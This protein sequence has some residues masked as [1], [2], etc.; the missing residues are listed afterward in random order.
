MKIPLIYWA[1]KIALRKSAGQAERLSSLLAQATIDL[2]PHQLHAVLFAFNSPL[3]RGAVLADEVGLGKTIEAGIVASQL[4][5]EDK[6][7]ILIIVPASLRKQWQEELETH[8][9]LR[10]TIVDKRY[11]DQ[12]INAGAPVPLTTEGIFIVSLPFLYRR[13]KLVEKQP[14]DLVIIDEAH[15]LRRVYRGRDA[16]KMAFELRKAIQDKPKLLLTAT[17]LQNDLLEVYGLVSFIDNKLL[18]SSYFFKTRFIEPIKQ[19]GAEDNPILRKIRE[20]ILGPEDGSDFE[21]PQGVVVRTL[22]R[23]VKHY[24]KFPPRQS[25]TADFDPGEQEWKLYE[26]VSAY[27]QRPDIAAIGRTQRNLMILV[28]RKLLASSSFAIAPT[29]KNLADRLRNELDLRQRAKKSEE[30]KEEGPEEFLEEAEEIEELEEAESLAGERITEEFSDED[31]KREINELGEYYNL[32]ISIKENAKGVALANTLKEVFIEAQRKGWPEKAIVFTESRRTQEYLRKTLV[33]NGFKITIFNGSNNSKEAQIAYENWKKEFPESA[34]QL[35]RSIAVRQALVHEFKTKTQVLLATEAGAEGL[36]LQFANIVVNYDLPWNPQRIE[37]RIGRSHRYGQNY[38]VLV[39]NMLNT[40]NYADKRLLELLQEKLNLFDGIFGSSDEILGAIEAG[41]DFD[42]KILEIYQTCKTPEEIDVAFEKLQ[43]ELEEARKKEIVDIRSRLI[44]YLDEPILQIFKK[45]KEETESVL[46]EYDEAMIN[47]C[48]LYFGDKMRA[49]KDTGLFEIEFKGEKK[50]YLFREEKEE[51]RGK[52]SRMH[53][54][55]PIIRHILGE[56]IKIVTKPIPIV[57]ILYTESGKRMHSLERLG[58]KGGMLYLFKLIVE[59][60]ETDE[61]LAPLFFIQEGNTWQALGLQ[62]GKFLIELSMRETA[63]GAEKS[64]LSKENLI[65]EWNKWKKQAVKRF[66]ERNERLYVREQARIER[67]WDSQTL[68]NQDKI[69]KL[70]QE[71]KELKRKKSNTID[72]GHLRELAQKIQQTEIRLQRLKIERVKI[73]AEALK[74]KEKDF[75]WLNKK[76]K[77]NKKEELLAVA[78]F[79]II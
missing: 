70:E 77:L 11:F 3:S 52:I 18:G 59:G 34:M 45:T 54:E 75:R 22:R 23:Q 20:L 37:Q 27:L 30:T 4:W 68:Q 15:R 61:A 42:K 65:E 1:N 35:S 6:R 74:G 26:L 67:F 51:E 49:T 33:E 40:K 25:F 28:Y 62:E 48:G 21:H 9:N 64:P 2:N 58:G 50:P 17:P 16:S 36:N 44:D 10:S 5:L 47:L 46:N 66:E 13:M 29:L 63:D 72:F 12:Q 56:V 14:W 7:R 38:E 71:I 79:K 60:I 57:E 53:R 41:L 55:H 31:I 76:L 39:V 69:E 8:F 73:E 24:I 32:A 43:G 19:E 78:K